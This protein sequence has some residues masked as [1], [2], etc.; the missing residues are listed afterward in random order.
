MGTEG[1]EGD[2]RKVGDE[3]ASAEA[4]PPEEV[5]VGPFGLVDDGE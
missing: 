5:P 4:D 2:E 1:L 3:T